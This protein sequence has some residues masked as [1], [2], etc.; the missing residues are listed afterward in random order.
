MPMDAHDIEQM[1]KAAI[2]D[3]QVTI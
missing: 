3:A 2:P 1:I